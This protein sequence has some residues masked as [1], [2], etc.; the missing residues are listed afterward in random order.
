MIRRAAA[1]V[2]LL[3]AALALHAWAG[4]DP[5]ALA[6]LVREGIDAQSA[7]AVHSAST[8][9]LR[10]ALPLPQLE[11]L[12]GRVHQAVGPLQA[13]ERRSQRGSSA[14]YLLRG[15]EAAVQ[16]QV[17]WDD[18]GRLSGLS[19]RPEIVAPPVA[20][21][22]PLRLPF[23]ETWTV[24][25]G[26]ATEADNYHVT[27][28]QQRRAADLGIT[29]A[30]GKTHQGDG[31]RNEDYYCYGKPILAAG[32]GRVVF[33]ID[34][35][36]DNV[37]G[38]LNG[39]M[40]LGNAVFVDHGDGTFALYA[41]LIPGSLEVAAGDALEPGQRLGRCGNSG[42]SSEPHLHFHLQDA[43]PVHT[44]WGVEPVFRGVELTRGGETTTPELY[45]WLQGD[46][47]GPAK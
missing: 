35:V 1:G 36:P 38:Q 24:T 40:A 45:T 10:A 47:V 41:H 7:A 26:G 42:N 27:N 6:R 3:S 33:A 31:T 30:E 8:P 22:Q 4:P 28:P 5:D 20:R 23:A 13:P 25:W 2:A 9:E 21:S 12:F 32:T 15:A 34:G 17:S 11:A 14:V 44:G 43:Q 37:P 19:L 16:L 29:D 46:W 18:A 39:Y